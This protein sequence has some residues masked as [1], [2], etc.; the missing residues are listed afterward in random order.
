MSTEIVDFDPYSSGASVPNELFAD[1]RARC[2]VARIPM[3][4]YLAR[5]DDV[6]TASKLVDTFVASFRA[7]GV[8]VPEEEK[9]VSEI[10]GARHGRIR[11]VINGAVA[12]HRSARLEPFVRELCEEYIEPIVSRGYGE[13][14]AELT[15]PIPINVIAQFTGVPRHHWAQFRQWSDEIVSGTYPALHRNERGEGL[16]GAHPE[17]A[18]YLDALI[19]SRAASNDPPDDLVT[20]LMDADIDGRRLSAVEVRSQIAFIILAGNETTR[21][22]LGNLL[23]RVATDRALFEQLRADRSLVERAVEESLRIDP[24][25]PML[26]RNVEQEATVFGPRMCPGEK[27]VFG[28][29]SANRDEAAYDEPDRFDLRRANW[30][31][32]VA[33]GAGPHVC[34]GASLARLEGQVLLDTFL[35]RVAEVSPDPGWTQRKTPVFF[36]NGPIDLP[37]RVVAAR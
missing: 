23:A 22:L 19:S 24:P 26:M 30:R 17:F 35:D 5:L 16:A 34:P 8:V 27:V 13:L 25:F 3:G 28:L 32:H 21:Q 36:A 7:P 10:A 20:R 15:A 6:V 14:V 31:E 4:W 29:A 2:P 9:F 12:H 37:V 1:M 33:F 11:R 18:A